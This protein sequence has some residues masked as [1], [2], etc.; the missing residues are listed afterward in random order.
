MTEN[1]DNTV[2]RAERQRQRLE[3]E[4]LA[5]IECFI[6]ADAK[7]RLERRGTIKDEAA[8]LIL[9]GLGVS[10]HPLLQG[11]RPIESLNTLTTEITGLKQRIDVLEKYITATRDAARDVLDQR[12]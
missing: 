1:T 9:L 12:A 5:R 4:G 8:A 10:E 7:D 11:D 2:S 6:P 3:K